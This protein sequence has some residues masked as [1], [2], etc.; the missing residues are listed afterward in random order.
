LE[1]DVMTISV[2]M[3]QTASS[4]QW[5]DQTTY[6]EDKGYPAH[7]SFFLGSKEMG[8]HMLMMRVVQDSTL[9]VFKF[10][11]QLVIGEEELYATLIWDVAVETPR[12]SASHRRR[13]S[14]TTNL[15]PS[16]YTLFSFKFNAVP[17]LAGDR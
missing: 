11:C 14:L 10:F 1:N 17:A 16:S 15:A 4:C 8:T 12:L 13:N 7:I 3:S 9:G 6:C 2:A 5:I